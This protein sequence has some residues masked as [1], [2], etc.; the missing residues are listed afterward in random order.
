[1]QMT[2]AE[3][4]D[5]EKYR[6]EDDLRTLARA[7]EIRGDKARMRKVRQLAKEQLAAAKKIAES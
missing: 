2:K 1:M 3:K 6:T 7:D 5:Q 4:A